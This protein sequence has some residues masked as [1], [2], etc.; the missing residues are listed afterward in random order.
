MMVHLNRFSRFFLATI[1][2]S[3]SVSALKAEVLHFFDPTGVNSGTRLLYGRGDW[4]MA[5]D[6]VSLRQLFKKWKGSYHPRSGD[7]IALQDAR[8]DLGIYFGKNYYAGYFSRYNAFIRTNHDFTDFYHTA[9]NKLPFDSTRTYRLKL[10]IAGIK[11]NGVIFSSSHILFED[12]TSIMKAGAALSLSLANDMQDGTVDGTAQIT[13][14]TSYTISARSGYHYT[15]NYLYHLRVKDADGFGLGTDFALSWYLKAYR[16]TAKLVVN[17]LFSRIYWHNLPYSFVNIVTENKSYDADGYVHYAPMINGL[18]KYVDFTQ[19]IEPRYRLLLKKNFLSGLRLSAGTGYAYKTLFPFV[20]AGSLFWSDHYL[21][22]T[23]ESRF[24][25]FGVEY[26]ARN[27]FFGFSTDALH[28]VSA[29][30]LNVGFRY[31]F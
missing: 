25:S 16:L 6:P 27:F 10:G 21:G 12:D 28:E 9:K 8:L 14:R 2:L 23:Y 31:R 17:D 22:I 11:E 19:K 30:G 3:V 29:L 1:L 15:H 4:F 26:N 13:D 5:N 18:E 20:R 7:N 24:R